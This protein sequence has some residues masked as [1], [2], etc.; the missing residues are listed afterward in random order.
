[1]ASVVGAKGQI[2]IDR[3]IRR[4]LGIRAGWRAVQQVVDNKVVVEFVPPAHERSLCGVLAGYAAGKPTLEELDLAE[5]AAA[6][7]A[8]EWR[9]KEPRLGALCSVALTEDTER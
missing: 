4:R 2:V 9:A 3:A 8:A 1:M 5:A 6:D 7:A